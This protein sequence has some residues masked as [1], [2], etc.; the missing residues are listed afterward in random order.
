[1]KNCPRCDLNYTDGTLEFCL[2]DGTRL[3]KIENFPTETPTVT[4]RNAPNLFTDQTVNLPFSNAAKTLESIGEKQSVMPPKNRNLQETVALQSNKLLEIAPF[5][6]ALA[7]NW[8]QW[9]YLNNQYYSTFSGYFLSANFLMWLLL[10][11]AGVIGG[12]IA[13][14]RCRNKALVFASLVIFSINLILFLVPK[15]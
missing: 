2:E 14:K 13:L 7:H 3:I 12:L 15:R 10:L 11:A 6:I 8:W 4:K 9:I 1:M 5:V